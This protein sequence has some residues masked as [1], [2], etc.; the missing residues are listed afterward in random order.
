MGPD[1][2]HGCLVCGKDLVYRPEPVTATCYI[3]GESHPADTLCVDG[4]YVC[5]RCYRAPAGEIIG[6][7]C[8]TTTETDPIAIARTLMEMPQLRTRASEQQY[9]IAAVLLAA[10]YNVKSMAGEKLKKIE[11]ARQRVSLIKGDFCG[12]YGDC[13][14][15]VGTG[16]FVS[17][18]TNATPLSKDEWK[19]TN[20]MT[21]KSLEAISLQ[22]GPRCCRRNAFI[23]ILAAVDFSREHFGVVMPVKEPVTC[24]CSS[25]RADCPTKDCPYYSE[26]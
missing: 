1:H 25:R 7:Y 23:A 15:A 8:G 22:G 21:A 12:I 5:D 11:Q 10:F 19:L 18:V 2:T 6:S 4:H 16:I 24:G 20:L 13:G 14:A 9:L 17:L 26:N 3:C